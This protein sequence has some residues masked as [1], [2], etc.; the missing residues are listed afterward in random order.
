MS[1]PGCYATNNQLLIA[2]LMPYLDLS[3]PPT[4]FGVSGY[5]GAGTKSGET[6]AEGRPT[7]VPKIVR[8]RAIRD[9][10]PF[11]LTLC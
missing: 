7:T 2:P 1:N 8:A 11:A 3:A 5:S 10:A 4:V 9:R 6:D